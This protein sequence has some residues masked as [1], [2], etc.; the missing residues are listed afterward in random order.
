MNHTLTTTYQIDTAIQELQTYLH[1]SLVSIWNIDINGIDAYGRV[2]RNM[3]E[4]ETIP[5]VYDS[6]SKTYKETYYN[7]RSCF[8]FIDDLSHTTDDEYQYEARCK[9]AFMLDLESIKSEVERSDAD[10][11]RDAIEFVRGFNGNFNITGFEKGIDEVFRGFKTDGIK[12]NDMQ[13]YHVFAIVGELSYFI[14]DKCD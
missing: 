12:W 10:A 6:T 8:F 14:N 2:Y 5:E 9:I 13:P 1:D 7:S 11:Q 4:G 3:R